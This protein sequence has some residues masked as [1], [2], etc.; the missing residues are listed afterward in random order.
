MRKVCLSKS[1]RYRPHRRVNPAERLEKLR[2]AQS[3]AVRFEIL[4]QEA[5]SRAAYHALRLDQLPH[6][7]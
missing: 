4:R 7:F 6:E 2:R 3:R 1:R 5:A